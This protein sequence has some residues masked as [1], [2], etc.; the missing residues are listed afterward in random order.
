MNIKK[1]I[2]KIIGHDWYAFDF[3]SFGWKLKDCHR[4]KL[5]N[6]YVDKDGYLH[7]VRNEK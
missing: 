2:C 1:I 7:I 5:A 6:Y 4:C 3:V